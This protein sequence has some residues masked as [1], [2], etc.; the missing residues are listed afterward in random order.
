MVTP[1]GFEEGA[2]AAPAAAAETAD[3]SISIDAS[4]AES[5]IA[6]SFIKIDTEGRDLDVLGGAL[7]TLERAQPAAVFEFQAGMIEALSATKPGDLFSH[8]ARIG[9][10][11]YLFRGHSVLA[12]EKVDFETLHRIYDLT[13]ASGNGGHWE[14]LLWPPRL[15]TLVKP[16]DRRRLDRARAPAT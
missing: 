11:P 6:P 7:Q 2:F 15:R 4:C 12:V 9:Y 16:F 5:G 13:V 8:L 14:V 10:S 3:E 1:E